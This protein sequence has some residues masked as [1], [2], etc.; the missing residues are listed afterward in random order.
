MRPWCVRGDA[1]DWLTGVLG[2]GLTLERGCVMRRLAVLAEV[3]CLP[4]CPAPSA[5]AMNDFERRRLTRSD[6]MPGGSLL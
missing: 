6:G 4:P 2:C 3:G 5:W 1:E